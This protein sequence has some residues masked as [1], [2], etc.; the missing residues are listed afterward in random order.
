M[1]ISRRIDA[2]DSSFAGV[3]LAT[4]DIDFF[5][6]FYDSL[7]LGQSGA[8]A[9][10]LNSGVMVVRRPFEDR[11][12]GKNVT[13]TAL[14]R[15]HLELGRSGVFTTR[16]SQDHITR[17][18]SLRELQDYPL[19]VAAALSEDEILAPWWRDTLWHASVTTVLA[20]VL[21]MFGV[22]FVRQVIA[23]TRIE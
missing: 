11:F 21:A 4:I 20:L 14:Y 18:N 9:L 2:P 7:D 1:P 22:R 19:F 17:L 6:R 5:S 10:V 16:S 12:V 13:D 23:R 3:A 15:A 8:A